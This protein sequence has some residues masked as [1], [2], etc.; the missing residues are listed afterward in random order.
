MKTVKPS[1]KQS[2]SKGTPDIIGLGRVSKKTKG[3]A[4]FTRD[5]WDTRYNGMP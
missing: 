1:K 5:W 3:G 2:P 4:G